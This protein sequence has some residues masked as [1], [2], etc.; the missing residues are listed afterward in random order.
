[1]PTDVRT[2]A[3]RL[4]NPLCLF[5]G[6]DLSA[7]RA[8]VAA[9]RTERAEVATLRKLLFAARREL[10]AELAS[11]I[12]AYRRWLGDRSQT[13]DEVLAD[14]DHDGIETES[15][16]QMNRWKRLIDTIDT[17]IAAAAKKT[18]GFRPARDEKRD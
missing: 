3:N 7:K 15:Y 11:N 14:T 2:V 10:A 17:A 5:G 6:D 18:A 1:M 9:L 16:A 4:I 8:V 12:E 13:D